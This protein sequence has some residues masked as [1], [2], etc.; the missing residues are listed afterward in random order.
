MKWRWVTN[1]IVLTLC[2]EVWSGVGVLSEGR[3]HWKSS[4]SRNHM[5]I[6]SLSSKPIHLFGYLQ[7]QYP[8]SAWYNTNDALFKMVMRQNSLITHYTTTESG[9]PSRNE[10][11]ARTS[12]AYCR[13]SNN[14]IKWSRSLSV[15]SEIQPSIGMALSTACQLLNIDWDNNP[16]TFM[17]YVTHGTVVYNH[18]FAQVWFDVTEVLDVCAVTCRTMLTIISCWEIWSLNF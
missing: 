4:A 18:D 10:R 8:R 2:V 14:G 15:G 5:L 7:T 17:E 9:C 6:R 11:I 12:V 16:L 13:P 3:E 1:W